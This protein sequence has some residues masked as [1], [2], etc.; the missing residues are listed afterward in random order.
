VVYVL[1]RED[2]ELDVLEGTAETGDASLQL[3]ERGARVRASIDERQR[4]SSIR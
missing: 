4:S 1:V 2:H 3:V